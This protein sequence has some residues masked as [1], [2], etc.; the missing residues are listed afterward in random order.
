MIM[1]LMYFGKKYLTVIALGYTQADINKLKNPDKKKKETNISNENKAKL[2]KEEANKEYKNE[3]F[4]QA[5]TLYSIALLITNLSDQDYSILYSNR[6]LAYLKLYQT[7]S[8]KT[9][10]RNVMRALNDAEMA[11]EL[12]P[13]WYKAFY[14]LGQIYNELYVLEKSQEYLKIALLIKPIDVEVKNLYAQVKYL[15]FEQ[16][17]MAH[18]DEQCAPRTTEENDL[19]IYEKKLNKL[20]LIIDQNGMKH[21]I[22]V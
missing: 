8:N 1:N 16:L 17:R 5:I 20:V 7:S 15:Y 10:Q 12:N 18:I 4:D 14:R 6:A 21:Q 22:F 3:N 11:S 13:K 9:D 2:I 19:R